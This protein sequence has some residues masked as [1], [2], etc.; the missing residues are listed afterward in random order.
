MIPLL[1]IPL[2]DMIHFDIAKKEEIEKKDKEDFQNLIKGSIP[3]R[4]HLE[5]LSQETPYDWTLKDLDTL[6]EQIK[7][8][9]ILHTNAIGSCSNH[10]DNITKLGE[11]LIRMKLIPNITFLKEGHSSSNF[12]FHSFTYPILDDMK[13]LLESIKF[14]KDLQIS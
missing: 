9:I 12:Y 13:A 8:L 6:S 4:T 11:T 1:N 10:R 7:E 5:S 3:I 2:A 14:L